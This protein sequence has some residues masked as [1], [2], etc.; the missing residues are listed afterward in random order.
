ML[1]QSGL[2]IHHFDLYS[3]ASQNL[4][5]AWD[6]K[7]TLGQWLSVSWINPLLDVAHQ[8]PLEDVDIGRLSEVNQAQRLSLGL[9]SARFVLL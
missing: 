6:E 2:H 5:V 9:I 3:R 1:A 4:T 8:R 7:A